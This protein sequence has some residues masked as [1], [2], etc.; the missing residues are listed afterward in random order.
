KQFWCED[1]LRDFSGSLEAIISELSDNVYIT[2]DVDVCDPSWIPSTGTPE[3]GGLNYYQ[4]RDILRAV[5]R[6]RN[7]VAMDC[8]ELTDGNA[9]AA[10]AI[11]RLLYKTIGYLSEE[12]AN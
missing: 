7:V 3:P 9:A 4:V 5:C 8:V 12:K 6:S 2:F 10:F 1:V 11:A